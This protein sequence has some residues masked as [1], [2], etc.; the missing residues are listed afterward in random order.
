MPS[1]A[2]M[3]AAPLS[4][5]ATAASLMS[6]TAA[7]TAAAAEAGLL[8]PSFCVVQLRVTATK[9]PPIPAEVAGGVPVSED[10]CLG[11]NAVVRLVKTGACL[12][13]RCLCLFCISW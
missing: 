4:E 6:P 8:V 1:R 3:S 12:H 13:C 9:V 5:K 10:D 11:G 2:T 7:G